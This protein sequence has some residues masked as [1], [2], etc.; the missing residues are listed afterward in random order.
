MSGFPTIQLGEV[1]TKVG[2]GST[3]RGGEAAYKSTGTP[4]IRS[5]NVHFGGFREDGLAY[6]DDDQAAALRNVEVRARDVLLNITG[7]SIGRVTIAPPHMDGARVNQHVC[8]IR[9]DD[10]LEPS[11]L[12]W[13]LASPHQQ[14]LINSMESGATRQA[15]TKEKIL[16][17]EVPLPSLE[18]QREIVA[19]LEKQFSR[20]DEAVAN[21]QRV[22]ANL[23]R[24]K[25]SVLKAAVEGRLVETEATLARREG[26][27]YETGEQLLQ[28]ILEER[29]RSWKGRGNYA[30]PIP[31]ADI[32]DSPLPEGWS[33]STL[34]SVTDSNRVICYG[35]LMPKDNVDDGVLFVKVRD[36]RGDSVDLNALHKTSYEI[37]AKYARA[38]LKT[39]DILLSIRGTYGRVAVVPPLLDGGNITQDTAR[40]A[41]SH[42]CNPEFVAVFLR[43][44]DAQRYF[45]R[46]ARGVAV[47]GV[48]IGDVRPMP[49]PIPPL[50]EQNRIVAEVDRH[51]SIIREVEAEVDTNLQRAQALRQSTLAKAFSPV[52]SNQVET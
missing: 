1:T 15:L 35:I 29:R 41:V 22:K 19:E 11:F 32:V 36:M 44:E 13:F 21:L 46:V 42:E 23:K 28:R 52:P 43:S 49:I 5:M 24:Y 14:R 27:T 51:L 4:L 8:I 6:I 16:A 40:I 31:V 25:A 34:E 20:L 37:A 33:S 18:E 9:P 30:N 39:G 3:P 38:S 45:K 10:R 17:F 12:R 2:S 48:N 47:K 26:R 7:A 50:A